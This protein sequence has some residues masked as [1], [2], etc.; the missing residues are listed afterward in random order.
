MRHPAT[1][2][3]WEWLEKGEGKDRPEEQR[4][5]IAATLNELDGELHKL[6]EGWPVPKD[7]VPGI[8]ADYWETAE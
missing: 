6:D 8:P 3:V 7:T 5:R 1:T 4:D 2:D